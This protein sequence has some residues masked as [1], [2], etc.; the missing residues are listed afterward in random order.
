M[1]NTQYAPFSASSYICRTSSASSSDVPGIGVAVVVPACTAWDVDIQ[2][3]CHS[4]R[5]GSR[6]RGPASGKGEH[7][8]GE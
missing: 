4:R 7:R 3:I 2:P 1:K 8:Q 6:E 5:R